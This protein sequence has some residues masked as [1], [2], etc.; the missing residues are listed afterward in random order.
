MADSL[1]WIVGAFIFVNA[2]WGVVLALRVAARKLDAGRRVGPRVA[3]AVLDSLSWPLVALW[4]LALA[5][6]VT[7]AVLLVLAK[8]AA[9]LALLGGFLLDAIAFWRAQ[10][11]ATGATHGARE[12]LTH[13]VLF[14]LLAVAN[15]GSRPLPAP[16]H[17]PGGPGPTVSGLGIEHDDSRRTPFW[18]VV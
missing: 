18:P 2:V 13:Y 17:G 14:G 10:R 4:L 3:D 7:S 9:V 5:L 1:R 11:R 12:R 15:L 8:A 16:P 6:F